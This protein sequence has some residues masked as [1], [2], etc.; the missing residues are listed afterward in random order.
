[1]RSSYEVTSLFQ[2]QP[3][4]GSGLSPYAISMTLH[5]AGIALVSWTLVHFPMI[6]PIPPSSR[7]Q[8]RELRLHMPER[9]PTSNDQLYPHTV[10]P[11]AASGAKASRPAPQAEALPQA[12][13]NIPLPQLPADLGLGK[14]ILLQPQLHLHQQLAEKIPVPNV[15][16]W[17]PELN[18]TKIIV[19]THPNR[20][21]VSMVQ[22]SVAEPNQEPEVSNL[23]LAAADRQPKV[24]T[25]PAASTSPIVQNGP[26][27]MKTA[28]ATTTTSSDQPTPT[29]VLS[30]SNLRMPDGVAVL[31][32]VNETAGQGNAGVSAPQSGAVGTKPSQAGGSGTTNGNS[33]G[34]SN[35]AAATGSSAGPAT[36]SPA[37]SST[38]AQAANF[39]N[40]DHIQLPP[41]GRFGVV[42]V[43]AS[44]T[45][46]YPEAGNIWTDRVAYT[47]YLHVGLPK[48]W[49]LQYGRLPE[50]QA[51]GSGSVARLEAPWPYDVF[52]PNLLAA[53]INADALMVHGVLNAS[54]K[55]EQLVVAFPEGFPRSSFVV[56][57]LSRWQ[58]RP[59]SQDGKPTPVEI[60]LIIPEED[61]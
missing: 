25:P 21:T 50:A 40:V 1:M 10:E 61:D 20:P 3:R 11:P 14:Q 4:V 52:R 12:A 29:A 28:P 30:V 49:I 41:N 18:R 39:E 5:L 53:D 48:T 27:T 23:N 22:P 33:S 55:L 54:G 13:K 31:P 2:P 56:N 44:Q 57:A 26:G 45:E 37:S 35:S 59:A 43:G 38:G 36:R 9:V 46:Q 17:M 42:V 15:I 34:S 47:V 16:M 6:R 32:P 19:P 51:N 24:P 60:L 7:F 8:V 58:F